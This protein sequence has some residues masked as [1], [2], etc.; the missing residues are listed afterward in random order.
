MTEADR[1]G[2][3]LQNFLNKNSNAGNFFFVAGG[4][5]LR[6]YLVFA[7]QSLPFKFFQT[8]SSYWLCAFLSFVSARHVQDSFCVDRCFLILHAG[9][10][11]DYSS[12]L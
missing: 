8:T 12:D 4:Q 3:V 10:H 2:F 9:A 6:T 5:T 1:L 11:C 7:L